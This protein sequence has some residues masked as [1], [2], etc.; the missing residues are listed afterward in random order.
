MIK[1]IFA[2]LF[3]L[4]LIFAVPMAVNASEG[5][6]DVSEKF[7]GYEDIKWASDEK[8]MVGTSDLTFSPNL[9]MT[10]A[11]LASVI[12]RYQGS[13]AS[14]QP[15]AF[16]D[17]KR[18]FWYTD[19]IDWAA[20]NGIVFGMSETK[21]APDNP[22]TREQFAAIL[23]RYASTL[24]IDTSAMAD[25][26]SFADHGNVSTWARKAM[27]WAVAQNL[28]YGIETADGDMLSPTGNTTRAQTAAILHRFNK[29]VKCV[30]EKEHEIVVDPARAATCV[31]TGLTEGSHCKGCG[32]VYVAQEE[33]PATGHSN[34]TVP[35]KD[36]SCTE[37]GF[38]EAVKCSVCDFVSVEASVIEA[39]GHTFS[40]WAVTLEPTFATDGS[41]ARVCST[42]GFEETNTLEKTVPPH[43]TEVIIGEYKYTYYTSHAT[44]APEGWNA[45]VTDKTKT[46]Y[47]A[48][49]TY[50]YDRPVTQLYKTYSG[51]SELTELPAIPETVSVLYNTY[52]NCKALACAPEISDN[53]TNMTF[54]FSGCSSLE[55]TPYI[56]AGV[57][58]KGT[59]KNCSA[60]TQ[61]PDISEAVNIEEAFNGCTALTGEAV[62]STNNNS[63][64]FRTSGITS[65]VIKPS[66]TKIHSATF[67]NCNSLVKVKYEGTAEEF[68]DIDV[69]AAYNAPF[70][71]A[72][73]ELSVIEE[74][75]VIVKDGVAY[76][77][78]LTAQLK[79]LFIAPGT[80]D[81]YRNTSDNKLVRALAEEIKESHIYSYKLN[82]GIYTVYIRNQDYT[83]ICINFT[84]E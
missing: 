7:W 18:D 80:W 37:A 55:E 51:C 81:N 76:I 53:V 31:D 14:A 16:T 32:K 10:R 4:A 67:Q 84:V 5:F 74:P 40:D 23:Y 2:V 82:S 26:S 44:G 3:V 77:C 72:V 25:L 28:I 17:I 69:T 12:W 27:E 60:L 59:F 34:E 48:P 42:C 63:K 49:E 20:E 61:M 71:N 64:A 15:S 24:A 8:L 47:S 21:F 62:I 57:I 66:V 33:I 56:P 50:V 43:G 70:I 1:R 78:G 35:G 6:S 73:V 22:I 13:P 79:D 30:D 39:T 11:M 46:C 9:E 38:T 41:E 68:L 52:K 65:V 83:G 54:A 19:G 36:A 58:L 75:E 45:E 29:L